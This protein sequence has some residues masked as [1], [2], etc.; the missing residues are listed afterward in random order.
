[1][2]KSIIYKIYK[3]IDEKKEGFED[4]E[5]N[6]RIGQPPCIGLY[7]IQ[8]IL[9]VLAIVTASVAHDN[10]KYLKYDSEVGIKVLKTPSKVDPEIVITCILNSSENLRSLDILLYDE[11]IYT[12]LY[13]GLQV[14]LYILFLW[15]LKHIN[16]KEFSEARYSILIR[17][18][19]SAVFNA[20]NIFFISV[21]I[22]R[23][24]SV[25]NIIENIIRSQQYEICPKEV[26]VVFDLDYY[27]RSIT[28]CLLICLFDSAINL[29]IDLDG[30]I[31]LRFNTPLLYDRFWL[32]II[33]NQ[34]QYW[35]LDQIMTLFCSPKPLEQTRSR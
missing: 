16:I 3:A 4:V 20:I 32:K 12:G 11:I 22:K 14:L 5:T 8:S 31:M 2:V 29:M 28:L 15:S 23:N 9:Y 19:V 10:L 6:I 24:I 17:D 33:K 26:T 27:W 30:L 13:I 34:S 18:S 7:F 35:C 21:A 1:M 25:F